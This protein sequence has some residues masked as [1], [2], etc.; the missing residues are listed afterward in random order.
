ML[1]VKNQLYQL[2]RP[3]PKTPSKYIRS[4]T[5]HT[6][7]SQLSVYDSHD[8]DDSAVFELQSDELHYEEEE[9]LHRP[10]RTFAS[11]PSP[12]TA[13]RLLD[14][15]KQESK[16]TGQRVKKSTRKHKDQKRREPKTE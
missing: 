15:V 16:A 1:H 5:S 12:T 3:T 6:L 13:K 10:V 9:E 7:T 11:P 14:Y 2:I 8:T 4:G